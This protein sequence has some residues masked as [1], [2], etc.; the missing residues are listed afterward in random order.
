MVKAMKELRNNVDCDAKFCDLEEAKKYYIPQTELPCAKDE[1]SGNDFDSYCT[2]FKEYKTE[3]SE[4]D[5]LEELAIVLNK[6][7][8][9]FDSGAEYKVVEF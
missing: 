4:A 5:S 2:Q 3:L 9:I 7:T 8:D 1:Y 6:Y